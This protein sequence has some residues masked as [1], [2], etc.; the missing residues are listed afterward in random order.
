MIYVLISKMKKHK[1]TC[2]NTD[3]TKKTA[4][5][6]NPLDQSGNTCVLLTNVWV[7]VSFISMIKIML[8]F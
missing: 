4:G 5:H 7:E 3:R 1:F 6:F 8:T 2:K